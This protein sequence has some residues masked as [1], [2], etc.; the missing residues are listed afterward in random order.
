M[1][2]KK[3]SVQMFDIPESAILNLK[4]LLFVNSNYSFTLVLYVQISIIDSNPFIFKTKFSD[5]SLKILIII[6]LNY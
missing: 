1:L 2:A 6:S 3:Q 4:K 5:S